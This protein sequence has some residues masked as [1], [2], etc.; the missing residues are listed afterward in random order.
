MS[1]KLCKIAWCLSFRDD[2][3]YPA[4]E[5]CVIHRVHPDY[6]PRRDRK[7]SQKKML[8]AI[9]KSEANDTTGGH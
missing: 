2:D 3:R 1:N 4:T 9:A 8:A 7:D 5:F 6:V